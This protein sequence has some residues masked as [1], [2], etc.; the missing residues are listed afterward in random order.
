MRGT[1]IR[2]HITTLASATPH[3]SLS[4]DSGHQGDEWLWLKGNSPGE[5]RAKKAWRG[6]ASTAPGAGKS[7][8]VGWGVRRWGGGAHGGKR[9][10]REGWER[11]KNNR[12]S[13]YLLNFRY[14]AKHICI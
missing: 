12:N 7:V 11:G 3:P 10:W 13:Q 9:S 1:E 2:E 8:G 5:S 4:S 14:C 6:L